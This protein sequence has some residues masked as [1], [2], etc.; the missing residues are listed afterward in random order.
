[1]DLGD[2]LELIESREDLSHFVQNL[3]KN[4]K[5]D[6]ESWENSSLDRFLEA[7]SAWVEDMEGYYQNRGES[8]PRQPDWKTFGQ[9]L[10]AAKC[11]E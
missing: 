11:Y 9:I 5:E 8:V 1:M 2:S 7:M 4:L 6:P 10:L 3:L